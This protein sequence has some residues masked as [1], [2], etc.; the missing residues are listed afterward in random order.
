MKLLVL[1][2]NSPNYSGLIRKKITISYIMIHRN[3]ESITC[4]IF[5]PGAVMEDLLGRLLNLNICQFTPH[6]RNNLA[7]EFRCYSNYDID[8]L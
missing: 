7:N 2:K 4:L 1:L 3:L 8:N 5:F 6:H